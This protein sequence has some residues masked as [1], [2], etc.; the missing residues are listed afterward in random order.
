V[1][2]VD[3]APTA[4]LSLS[5][6]NY[7]RA[8]QLQSALTSQINTTEALMSLRAC[9]LNRNDSHIFVYLQNKAWVMIWE[10]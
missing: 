2:G 8:K 4:P 7:I 3:V 9:E 10:F 6:P 5:L 1:D